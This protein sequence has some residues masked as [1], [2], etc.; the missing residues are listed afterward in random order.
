MGWYSKYTKNSYNSAPKKKKQSEFKKWMENLNEHLSKDILELP[1][2]HK[3]MLN[4]IIRKVQI[5]ATMIYHLTLVTM[6]VLKKTNNK[7]E[8]HIEKRGLIHSR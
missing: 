6:A 5:K 8:K 1:Q 2:A 3:K 4:A 7:C